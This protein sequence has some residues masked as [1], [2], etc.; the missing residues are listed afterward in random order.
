MSDLKKFTKYF[1]TLIWDNK[2]KVRF[3]IYLIATLLSVGLSSVTSIYIKKLVDEGIFGK[4]LENL[5]IYS[6]ITL[7]LWIFAI[8]FS[9]GA[10]YLLR[11]LRNS[12]EYSLK[13]SLLEKFLSNK[14]ISEK[15]SGYYL[16]RIYNEPEIL[17][18]GLINT[19]SGLILSLIWVILGFTIGF[20][21]APKLCLFIIPFIII[22]II[23]NY[24]IGDK[25]KILFKQ[26]SEENAKVEGFLNS[27]IQARKMVIV[28]GFLKHTLNK[29]GEKLTE[30][31]KTAT[32]A[33]LFSIYTNSLQSFLQMVMQIS[34]LFLAGF[35][36]IKGRFTIGAYI[37]FNSILWQ[38]LSAI[39]SGYDK[40]VAIRKVSGV[41][42]RI[43]ELLYPEEKYKLYETGEQKIKVFEVEHSS[44]A[45]GNKKLN[46]NFA[47][48][49]KILITGENGSGKTT[50]LNFIAGLKIP[51]KG[52]IFMPKNKRIVYSFMEPI[53]FEGTVLEN[54]GYFDM[55]EE[56]RKKCDELMKKLDIEKYGDTLATS[57]SSGEKRKVD[58]LRALVHDADI[59]IFDE[60]FANLDLDGKKA[61]KDL[62]EKYTKGK[63][64]IIAVPSEDE[65]LRQMGFDSK[66]NLNGGKNENN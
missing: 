5:C 29:F 57:L 4:N 64:V 62:I 48:G 9:L 15:P 50:L 39:D 7:A 63:T 59:Y 33:S 42:E 19:S 31:I 12:V 18:D 55:D 3:S 28:F 61:V 65:L 56:T 11:M 30:F 25:Y 49:K 32:K 58:L 51:D 52:K 53:F 1:R 21:I 54:I 23:I 41:I 40:I 66:I 22:N 46:L 45:K 35:E 20:Y 44:I 43:D 13:I 60:P 17:I 16:S 27:L 47:T 24:K 8:I 14:H 37:G 2:E 38:L 34:L 6:L 10:S 36:I 26:R